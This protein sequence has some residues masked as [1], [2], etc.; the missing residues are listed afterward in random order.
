VI[1]FATVLII[2]KL[3]DAAKERGVAYHNKMLTAFRRVEKSRSAFVDGAQRFLNPPEKDIFG[4][5][6]KPRDPV[7]AVPALKSGLD[8]FETTM[9]SV[10]PEISS[11]NVPGPER[12]LHDKFV[13]LFTLEQESLPRFREVIAICETKTLSAE[14]KRKRSRQLLEAI[15]TDE[16][17]CFDELAQAEKEFGKR[18]HLIMIPDVRPSL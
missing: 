16:R 3:E 10:A 18:Y 11:W 13:R 17:S 7:V 15:D 4:T 8:E 2:A 5:P 14:E 6:I 9:K 12:D 1:V